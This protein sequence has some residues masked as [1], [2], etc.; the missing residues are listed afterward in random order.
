MSGF[1]FFAL[2]AMVTG[3]VFAFVLHPVMISRDAD[4]QA[5]M[6]G[7]A[8]ALAIACAAGALAVYLVFGS[9]ALIGAL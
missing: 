5:G 8:A 3:G 2:A 6:R 4:T 1:V 7:W 9:P